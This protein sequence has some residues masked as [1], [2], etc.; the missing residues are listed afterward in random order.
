MWDH[1]LKDYN[2]YFVSNFYLKY[3]EEFASV[4]ILSSS[5]TR[6]YG[7]KDEVDVLFGH[8]PQSHLSYCG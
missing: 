8:R 6:K 1:I 4:P 7:A 3:L 2:Y 5:P